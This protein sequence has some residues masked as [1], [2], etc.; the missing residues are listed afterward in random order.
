MA[1]A[2]LNAPGVVASIG[3]RVA[4]GVTQHVGVN[5]KGE[6]GALTDALDQPI[7]A[8]GVNGPPRSVASTKVET[9]D[10]RRSS[11]SAR[12]SSPRSG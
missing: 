7:D 2:I 8:S 4:A 10:C 6:A 5:R 12:T 9:E 3:Q 11:R 1:E